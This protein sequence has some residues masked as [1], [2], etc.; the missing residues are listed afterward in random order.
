MQN[1]LVFILKNMQVLIATVLLYCFPW[2]A[3][4]DVMNVT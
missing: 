4:T 2:D 1:Y 3:N